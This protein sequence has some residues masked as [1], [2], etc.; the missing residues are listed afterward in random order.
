MSGVTADIAGEWNA[1]PTLRNNRMPS[2]TQMGGC[3]LSAMIA[4]ATPASAMNKSAPIMTAFLLP[5][6]LVT[7]F[8][9]MNTGGLPFAGEHFGTLFAFMLGGFSVWGAWWFLKRVGI[10]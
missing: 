7:G 3:A 1:E 5:P 2:T 10:L 8:F 6:T 9:G 4:S